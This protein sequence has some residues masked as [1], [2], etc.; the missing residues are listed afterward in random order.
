MSD[1]KKEPHSYILVR[2]ATE[3]QR[4]ERQYNA[5]QANI[6]YL[7][8]P[9]I[10]VHD[11]M[12]IADIGTGTACVEILQ[13][14]KAFYLLNDGTFR[15]WLKDLSA[16]LPS[17]CQLHGFDIS[18]TMFPAKDSLPSNITLFE[19]N[20]LESFPTQFRGFYDVVNVR[21]MIVAL[22]SD[23]WGTAVQNL[24]TLLRPGGWLQWV[25]CAG[26]EATVQGVANEQEKA[27]GAR[28]YLEHFS[29]TAVYCGKTPKQVQHHLPFESN[30]LKNIFQTSGL[31]NCQEHIYPLTEP[32]AR[33]E[34]NFAVLEG[35][36]NTLLAALESGYRK[37]VKSRTDV[38]SA[39]Q[40]AEN[41]L[42]EHRCWFTYNVH[43][44]IGMSPH[45]CSEEVIS[46]RE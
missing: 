31:I 43:V 8:N 14:I 17:T 45:Q 28:S 26:H 30:E 11:D 42:R 37:R 15:I 9:A 36:Q 24:M 34:L 13:Q 6:K 12:R 33:D 35:V 4:L 44:V 18:N 41:D 25:D 5:W 22:S 46:A 21:L 20:M 29:E 39:R 10:A 2:S 16:N 38:V 27:V 32:A 1:L 3:A 40:A 23:Q 7:L 19:Q